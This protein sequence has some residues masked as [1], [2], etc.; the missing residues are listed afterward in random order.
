[1]AEVSTPGSADRSSTQN[2]LTFRFEHDASHFDAAY[3]YIERARSFAPGNSMI[4]SQEAAQLVDLGKLNEA[5]LLAERAIAIAP[6]EAFSYTVLGY[7]YFQQS[8]TAE[9]IKM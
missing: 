1:M 4:L 3:R 2:Y 8:K 7:C 5:V 9:A 6:N